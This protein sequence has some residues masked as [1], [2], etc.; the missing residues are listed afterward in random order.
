VGVLGVAGS[1]Y[2]ERASQVRQSAGLVFDRGDGAGGA[3]ELH[4]ETAGLDP[5]LANQGL[6][7][8][9]DVAMSEL[10][11]ELERPPALD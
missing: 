4:G 9:G 3:D 11:P 2:F 10:G 8:A 6:E 1:E 5:A 7:L